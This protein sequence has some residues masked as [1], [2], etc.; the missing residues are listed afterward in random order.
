MYLQLREQIPST[1]DP[2]DL[3]HYLAYIVPDAHPNDCLQ[4]MIPRIAT[5]IRDDEYRGL[6]RMFVRRLLWVG[7]D[8]WADTERAAIRDFCN[9]LWCERL[10]GSDLSAL[11]E[12]VD[13]A[14]LGLAI[15][16]LLLWWASE[17]DTAIQLHAADLV[18]Q[19]MRQL[20]ENRPYWSEI[21]DEMASAVLY[22]GKRVTEWL[23][24][25]KVQSN[26]ECLWLSGPIAADASKEE[27]VRMAIEFLY[28]LH[29]TQP[30][31]REGVLEGDVLGPVAVRVS[32]VDSAKV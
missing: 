21:Q 3:Y 14:P 32:A 8:K 22:V 20:Q 24:T 10:R 6:L 31:D 25:P 18:C 23:L 27:R 5:A 16:D 9:S 13:S 30:K 15:D 19:G 7:W 11:E 26:L 4:A 29:E 2:S 12:V 17:T 28:S 1:I